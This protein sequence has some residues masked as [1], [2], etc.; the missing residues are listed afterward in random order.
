MGQ[1]SLDAQAEIL[2]G[3]QNMARITRD[4]HDRTASAPTLGSLRPGQANREAG[5]LTVRPV[6]VATA[7]S[8]A[9]RREWSALNATSSSAYAQY[10]SPE[11]VEH[12]QATY[13]E[14]LL[15][16]IV[17]QDH[18][19]KLAGI[20]PLARCDYA[21]PC[22][23]RGR[24]L[25]RWRVP[26]ISLLGSDPLVPPDAA[27]HDRL[28]AAIAASDPHA[29]AIYLHSLPTSSFCWSYL[30]SSAWIREHFLLHVAA[31]PRPFHLLHVPPSFEDFVSRFKPKKRYN[32]ARQVRVLRD[33]VGGDLR[34]QRI[35][36]VA[37][38]PAFAAAARSVLRIAEA[39]LGRLPA[40]AADASEADKLADV[41]RRGLLRS[42]VLFAGATPCAVVLGYIWRHIFHYAEVAYHPH[43]SSFSPGT[44]LLYLM[45]GDLIAHQR[46]HLVNFGIG[47]A[48]YKRAFTDVHL[49]DAS[50][51]L[52]RKGIANSLRRTG[53]AG[54]LA[55]MRGARRLGSWPALQARLRQ[56]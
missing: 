7:L 56:G 37:Q 28:F 43:F 48:A 22:I 41:A 50:V 20:V 33:H 14:E 35:D 31:G 55:L 54:F 3:V 49:E 9:L 13:P 18:G 17:A 30:Q 32:L 42:Y 11:W 53:H 8:G 2:G 15:A 46:P 38:V 36:A 16:P 25:W 5:E 4:A 1:D 51:L 44:V 23:A 27:T 40:V 21:L 6:P 52:L 34:L 24:V 12:V 47:D 45:I 19:R 26:A 39:R 10:A 29:G